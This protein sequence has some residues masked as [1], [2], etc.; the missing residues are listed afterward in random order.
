MGLF[1]EWCWRWRCV[2]RNRRTRARVNLYDRDYDL[3]VLRTRQFGAYEVIRK[4]ARGMTDVYLAF[5]TSANRHAVLKIV[6]ESPDALTQLI[7]EAERRGADLQKQLHDADSR[8]I[9]LYEYGHL[10]GFFFVSMQYIE[11]R[12][13]A[14]ILKQEGRIE[15]AAGGAIRG[16]DSEPARQAA[17]VSSHYRWAAAIRGA[18]RHQAVEHSDREQRR[19][20]AAGFWHCEGADFHSQ[21][22]AFGIGQPQLLLAGTIEPRA[23]GP[24][25]GSLG[26]GRN[27]VRDGG[28]RAAVSGAGYAQTGSADSIAAASARAARK[29]SGCDDRDSAQGAGGRSAPALCVGVG[30]RK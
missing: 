24:A 18:W 19:S 4:L 30:V 29:L 10:D 13:V 23:S 7:L 2:G 22:H 20:P 17:F 27:V 21:P 15:P 1:W 26:D 16:R 9:E 25:R 14:E 11:G 12:T 6:E 3:I 8:V 28:G 5:D